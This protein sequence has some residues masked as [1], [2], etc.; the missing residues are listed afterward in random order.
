MTYD[1]SAFRSAMAFDGARANL[2][3]VTFIFPAVLGRSAASQEMTFM[4]KSAS[5]PGTSFGTVPLFYFGRELKFAGNRTFADWTVTVIN[6]EDFQTR[7]A[8]EAW[9]NGI[10]THVSNLR[11]IGVS[12]SQYQVDAQILQYGKAGNALK[13]Y[14]MIGLFPVD[15]SAI[16]TDWGTND[17]IEDYT[18][19]LAYQ[20][21]EA[22]APGGQ[23]VTDGISGPL[24]LPTIVPTT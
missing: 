3:E 15:L 13:G 21:W 8:F 18:V 19:T 14:N 17:T 20:W 11:T 16:D 6:D 12:P 22:S 23:L 7:N 1:V 10:N 24:T 2:F 9:M 4:C 5:L